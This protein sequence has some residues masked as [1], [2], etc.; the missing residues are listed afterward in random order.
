[1]TPR[2]NPKI[3]NSPE[4]Q[5]EAET[6]RSQ[7]KGLLVETVVPETGAPLEKVILPGVGLRYGPTGVSKATVSGKVVLA[8]GE[9]DNT[10][11][12][13]MQDGAKVGEFFGAAFATDAADN[14]IAAVN[15]EDEIILIEESTG[16]EL[17]RFAFGWPVRLA[18]FVPGKQAILLVLTADQVVHKIPLGDAAKAEVAGSN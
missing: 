11:I 16:Q 18:Q 8:R 3:K 9:H 17:D 15:R 1:M 7:K 4:L 5:K 10:A 2:Q 12:Y 6:A 13:R 14:L